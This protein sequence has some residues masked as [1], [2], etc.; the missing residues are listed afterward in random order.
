MTAVRV[1]PPLDGASAADAVAEAVGAAA[2]PRPV[3]LGEVAARAIWV[4][5]DPA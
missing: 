3:E 2:E 1:L 5:L 4:L